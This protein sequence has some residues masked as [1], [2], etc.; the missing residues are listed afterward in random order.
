MPMPRRCRHETIDTGRIDAAQV[1]AAHSEPVSI[2]ELE[3]LDRHLAAIV[4]AVPEI[5]SREPAV[6]RV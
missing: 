6:R 2:E 4:Q 5:T 1:A 3:N